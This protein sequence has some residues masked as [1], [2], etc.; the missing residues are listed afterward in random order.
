VPHGGEYHYRSAPGSEWH[1]NDPEAMA[2]LQAAAQVGLAHQPA[3]L[4][5]PTVEKGVCGGGGV[6]VVV[7]VRG[8]STPAAKRRLEGAV[9]APRQPA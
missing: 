1:L 8:T 7:V 2:K 9:A 3:C 4:P 5:G 6:V